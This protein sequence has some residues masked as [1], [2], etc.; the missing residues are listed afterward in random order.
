LI[1]LYLKYYAKKKE[2]KATK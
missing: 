2:G 1:P